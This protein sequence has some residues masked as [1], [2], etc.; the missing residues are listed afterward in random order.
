MKR[1]DEK[2]I[3]THRASNA[4]YAK[5]DVQDRCAEA[6]ITHQNFFDSKAHQARVQAVLDVVNTFFTVKKAVYVN[7]RSGRGAPFTVVKVEQPNFPN[8]LSSRVKKELYR[9]PLAELGVEPVFSKNT[10]SY[11]YRI[12]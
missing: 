11:L 4:W 3:G 12:Y 8:H 10:N 2:I 9:E 1:E 7:Q 5:K 6:Y